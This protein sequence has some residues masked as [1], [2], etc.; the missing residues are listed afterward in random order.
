MMKKLLLSLI[1]SFLLSSVSIAQDVK[2][3]FK[4]SGKPIIRVFSN[5]NSTFS[6]GETKS[7]FDL[8]RVYLGYEHN[9]S[10]NF[11]GTVVYDV[12][13]PGT[14]KFE[15]TGFVKNAYLAYEKDKL[16]VDFG[17]IS[18]TQ[19][20][21]QEGFWGYRYMEKS[22]QDAYEFASSADLG[23]SVTYEF[24]KA[25]SADFAL[26]NGEGY[27]KLQSDDYLKPTFGLTISPIKQILIRGMFDTMGDD[28]LQQTYAG[29]IG[30]KSGNLSLAAEYNYQK[31]NKMIDGNNFFGPSFY[32]T[33]KA[34]KKIKLFARYDD[35]QSDTPPNKTSNW[36]LAKDGKLFITGF[37]FAPVNGIKLTPNYR[38]FS[39][40]DNSKP[41]VST[42]MINCE[43]KF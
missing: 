37:E 2:E 38:G 7:A 32:G 16:S 40:A 41:F 22:F 6:D 9:F 28:V 33:Y 31:N 42:L 27:K 29:F 30:Y 25:I 14:G 15:L 11:S 43:I 24:N 3:S 8:T 1:A 18:T 20:K 35:L 21:V 19:F 23:A 17:M 5:V 34:T 10:E 36:N 4:P 26:Y 12:G 39:P 13:N